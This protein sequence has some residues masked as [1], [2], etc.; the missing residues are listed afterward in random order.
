MRD[1]DRYSEQVLKQNYE[2]RNYRSSEHHGVITITYEVFDRS[3]GAGTGA[4]AGAGVG[5]IGAV[6]ALGVGLAVPPL[7]PVA[8]P[9]AIGSL[10]A[11]AAGAG[12]GA[13][14]GAWRSMEHYF[15]ASTGELCTSRNQAERKVRERI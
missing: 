5:V 3:A 12:I 9:A 10:Y 8:V 6:G 2:I 4:I 13:A 15:V 14:I 11:P 1:V 7:L